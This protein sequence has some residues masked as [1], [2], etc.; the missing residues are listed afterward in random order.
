[1]A[2]CGYLFNRVEALVDAPLE[3]ELGVLP[4]VPGEQAHFFVVLQ[5]P[6][7][8]TH[9]EKGFRRSVCLGRWAGISIYTIDSV[10]RAAGACSRLED[11]LKDK[12]IVLILSDLELLIL[13]NGN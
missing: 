2:P 13:K 7:I 1:M 11:T 3:Q 9:S 5:Q 10:F 12:F 4:M 8:T 6:S